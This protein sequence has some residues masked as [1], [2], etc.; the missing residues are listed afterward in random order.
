MS[1]SRWQR[2]DVN[3]FFSIYFKD[4]SC[5]SCA[6]TWAPFNAMTIY[7][8]EWLKNCFILWSPHLHIH[9]IQQKK[10]KK[11]NGEKNV[12]TEWFEFS[13]FFNAIVFFISCARNI[14]GACLRELNK[15]CSLA[16]NV[17]VIYLCLAPHAALPNIKRWQ[18]WQRN[19]N[20]KKPDAF[21]NHSAH[22]FSICVSLMLATFTSTKMKWNRVGMTTTMV[23]IIVQ[24]FM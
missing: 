11:N 21:T 23:I 16:F 6:R 5:V 18:S 20:D 15:V 8:Y 12:Q 2:V 22:C 1:L 3:K 10:Q 14:G 7:V 13:I 24:I 19:A 9:I 17:S 4:E